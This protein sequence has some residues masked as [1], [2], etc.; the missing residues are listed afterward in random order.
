MLN[1]EE[2]EILFSYPLMESIKIID[3]IT[4]FVLKNPSNFPITSSI[5]KFAKYNN[6]TKLK[7]YFTRETV[8]QAIHLFY[9]SYGLNQGRYE[10]Q[11]NFTSILLYILLVSEGMQYSQFFIIS[12]NDNDVWIAFSIGE[13]KKYYIFNSNCTNGLYVIDKDDYYGFITSLSH[14]TIDDVLNTEL[15]QDYYKLP[16]D[17]VVSEENSTEF[18]KYLDRYELLMR[19]ISGKATRKITVNDPDF[20]NLVYFEN[21]LENNNGRSIMY[22]CREKGNNME[23]QLRS[24]LKKANKV[25]IKS[26]FQQKITDDVDPLF[27]R[28][29]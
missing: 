21:D 14:K 16:L 25:S 12:K 5:M 6:K 4:D 27:D 22:M 1:K 11:N 28:Y 3:Y 10:H 2:K 24:Y 20:K 23:Y 7:S 26:V 9:N 29:I 8:K 13:S 19:F 15:T 18:E 17:L